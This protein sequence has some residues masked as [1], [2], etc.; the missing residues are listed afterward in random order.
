M[1][2]QIQQEEW[3]QLAEANSVLSKLLNRRLIIITDRAD[4]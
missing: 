4:T 1:M 2:Q 3:S